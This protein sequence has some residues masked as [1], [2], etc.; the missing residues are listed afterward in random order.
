MIKN[1]G[2]FEEFEIVE[3]TKYGISA[4]NGLIKC[5]DLLKAA[6]NKYCADPE[7]E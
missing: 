5:R 3:E 4:N 1:R 7:L 6:F 2:D